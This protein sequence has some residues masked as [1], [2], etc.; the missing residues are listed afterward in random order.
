MPRT[1]AQQWIAMMIS[2][3]MHNMHMHNMHC[4]II[5]KLMIVCKQV[6]Q[7]WPNDVYQSFRM[8][9][10]WLIIS[11]PGVPIRWA[12]SSAR[13]PTATVQKLTSQRKSNSNYINGE[14]SSKS[15]NYNEIFSRSYVWLPEANFNLQLNTQPGFL[16][17]NSGRRAEQQN[18][19]SCSASNSL[20]FTTS[21]PVGRLR[22]VTN[23]RSGVSKHITF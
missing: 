17:C 1:S 5:W 9:G 4:W 22:E 20:S 13:Q 14:V 2:M 19:T 10:S 12:I 18:A 11:S 7:S 8:V 6:Y 3:L 16:A 21:F 23:N 15:S